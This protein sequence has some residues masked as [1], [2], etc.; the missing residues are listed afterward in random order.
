M[1]GLKRSPV[2]TAVALALVAGCEPADYPTV[3][4][5]PGEPPPPPTVFSYVVPAGVEEV[6]AVNV[7]GSFQDPQWS[8]TATPMTE[9][10]PGT[11]EVSVQVQRGEYEYK[12]I[13][14]GDQWAGNMCNDAT[15]GD[16]DN[17]G[18]VDPD[19]TTCTGGGNAVLVVQ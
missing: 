7:A 16:A 4:R 18:K 17:G 3:P 9:T 6:A 10:S 1:P 13:F 19:V 14:N 11:W 12:Y 2:L 15:W 5:N 8:A